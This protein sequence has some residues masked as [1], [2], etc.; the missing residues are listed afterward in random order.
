MVGAGW[1]VVDRLEA[2]AAWVKGVARRDLEVGD[3][4]V[5]APGG[6]ELRLAGSQRTWKNKKLRW[7]DSLESRLRSGPWGACERI[8]FNW[9]LLIVALQS[10]V[11]F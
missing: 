9:L 10:C 2:Q 1:G 4:E 3:R 5:C 7:I 6:E 11:S 8:F